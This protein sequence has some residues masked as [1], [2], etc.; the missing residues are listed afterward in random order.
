[1]TDGGVGLGL[2]TLRREFVKRKEIL[3]EYSVRW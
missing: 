3:A 1:M 2:L